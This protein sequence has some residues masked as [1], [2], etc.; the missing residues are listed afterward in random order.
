MFQSGTRIFPS[1]CPSNYR[2]V[3]LIP[4]RAHSV[5]RIR[6]FRQAVEPFV[7]I[8]STNAA[9]EL[10][11]AA[12]PDGNRSSNTFSM[13]NEKMLETAH[14]NQGGDRKLFQNRSRHDFRYSPRP[15]IRGELKE[16]FYAPD[17]AADVDML[18]RD[19]EICPFH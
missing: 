14:S 8:A 12:M 17:G 13:A 2:S 16:R 4:Y 10:Q 1:A 3:R 9:H 11:L 15:H 5:T 18:A 7:P 19:A 6:R